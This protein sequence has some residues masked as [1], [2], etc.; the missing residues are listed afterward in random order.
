MTIARREGFARRTFRGWVGP[1][2]RSWSG[3]PGTT[4]WTRLLAPLS[5]LYGAASARAR[6]NARKTRRN[7][8]GLHVV[9]VGGITVGGSGKSALARWLASEC[10]AVG[11][12]PAL[13]LRGYRSSPLHRNSTGV[14]PDFDGYPTGLLALRAGDEAAAHRSALGRE[15]VVAVDRDRLRAARAVRDGYGATVAMLDDGWEQG[16]LGWNELWVVLDPVRPFGNGALLP[17]GP[18]RRPPRTLSEASVLALIFEEGRETL[19]AALL[20][21]LKRLAPDARVIRF[22]R[23]LEGITALGERRAIAPPAGG[24]QPRVALISGVGAPGRLERFA[25]GAGLEVVFHAEFPDHVRWRGSEVREASR[26]AQKAGAELVLLTDKDEPRWPDAAD[27]PLPVSVLRTSLRPLDET[28]PAL[29]AIRGA[30][31]AAGPIG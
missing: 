31:A 7:I 25:L 2:E 18:L 10:L 8:P 16:S 4:S 23:V 15:A 21:R 13:L 29:A 6:A 3:G 1:F 5:A 27:G 22:L 14:L 26:E 24:K 9:A 28:G 30:V 17:A 20:E 11:G 19:S 12:R